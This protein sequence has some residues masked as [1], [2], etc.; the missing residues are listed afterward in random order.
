MP[1]PASRRLDSAASIRPGEPLLPG[2]GRLA[3]A[4]VEGATALV[5]CAAASPLQILSPRRRGPSAWAVLSSHGGGLVSGD[6][7]A[8]T[9][10]VGPGAVALVGTQ[11][12]GKV[13]RSH[14]A[15]AEQRVDAHVSAGGVLAFLPEP[16]SCFAGSRYLQRQR[17]ALD[18]GASLLLADAV[19]AGRSARGERWSFER[20]ESRSEIRAGAKLVLRDAILLEAAGGPLAERMGRLGSIAVLVLIGPAFAGAAGRILAG[21]SSAPVERRSS[22]LAAAS[23]LA[24]GLLLRAGAERVEDLGAFLRAQLSFLETTLGEDPFARKW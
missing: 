6:R 5:A 21:I 22:L 18:P 17:F 8:L 2:E 13:Y 4:R 3:F 15:P 10:E 20:Y 24:D 1:Q 14:R 9:L 19:T 23:P 11:A 12:Q 16:V 7:V